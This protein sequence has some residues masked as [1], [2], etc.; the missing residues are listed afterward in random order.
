MSSGERKRINPEIIKYIFTYNAITYI[1]RDRKWV[2]G[3]GRGRTGTDCKWAQ[4]KFGGGLRVQTLDC[5][6]DG[7]HVPSPGPSVL[8]LSTDVLFSMVSYLTSLQFL[9]Q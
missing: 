9:H 8:L 1:F 2:G 4:G 3:W 6:D 5:G 7:S